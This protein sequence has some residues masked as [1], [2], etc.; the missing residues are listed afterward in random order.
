MGWLRF[1]WLLRL[2]HIYAAIVLV[3][4]VFF[5]TVVLMPA[6]RR[7]PPAHSAVV[8]QKIGA[9]LMWLGGAA[10]LLLGV[11]G[12]VRLWMLGYFPAMLSRRALKIASFRWLAL[13]IASWAAL[14]GTGTLS[15]TWYRTILTKKLPYSAGLRELE[16]RRAEQARVSGWQ[17]RLAYINLTLAVLA[18]LGGIMASS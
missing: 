17:D 1:Y 10:I 12:F 5:N 11:T 4:A 3:G 7:I 6:L 13:M 16:D 2:V 18:A 14:F 15:A 9:G 8:A